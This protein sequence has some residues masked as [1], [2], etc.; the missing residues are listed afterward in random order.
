MLRP[1]FNGIKASVLEKENML[2]ALKAVA[3][4]VEEGEVCWDPLQSA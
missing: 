2:L 3:A 1:G 4:A